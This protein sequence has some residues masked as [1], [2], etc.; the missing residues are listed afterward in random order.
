MNNTNY[1]HGK[2]TLF[3]IRANG[4][5]EANDARHSFSQEHNNPHGGMNPVIHR[6]ITAFF[7]PAKPHYTHITFLF[8]NILKTSIL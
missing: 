2:N 3:L 4:L 8:F 7:A 1:R 5:A 6:K